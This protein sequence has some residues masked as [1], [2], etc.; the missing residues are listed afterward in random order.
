MYLVI[1]GWIF[2]LNCFRNEERNEENKVMKFKK[3]MLNIS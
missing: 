2:Y 3:G 1:Q